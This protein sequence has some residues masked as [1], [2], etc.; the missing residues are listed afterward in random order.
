MFDHAGI[1]AELACTY[2]CS[3]QTAYGALKKVAGRVDRPLVI[4]GAGGVGFAALQIAAVLIAV[5]W[6][7]ARDEAHVAGSLAVSCLL[8]FVAELIGRFLFYASHRRVRL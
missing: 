3:G 7:G 8:L 1:P 2:A 4:L 6:W 5:A